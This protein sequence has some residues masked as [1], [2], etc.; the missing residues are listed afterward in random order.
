MKLV[1]V[2]MGIWKFGVRIVKFI[3]ERVNYGIDC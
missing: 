3:K 2:V 1:R